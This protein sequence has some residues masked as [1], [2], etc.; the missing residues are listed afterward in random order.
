MDQRAAPPTAPLISIRRPLLSSNSA[1][2]L[3][4]D[5][6]S[7]SQTHVE[8]Q[9]RELVKLARL[10]TAL[11]SGLRRRGVEDLAASLGAAAGVAAFK[12]A[13]ESWARDDS[14]EALAQVIREAVDTSR[15]LQPGPRWSTR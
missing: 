1:A 6:T 10:A 5:A 3:H 4:D 9:E 12:I 13:F 7:S 15:R 2:I 11:S 14:E 8:L